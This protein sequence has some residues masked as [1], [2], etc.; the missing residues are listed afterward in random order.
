VHEAATAEEALAALGVGHGF[1]L[2]VLDEIYSDI[3]EAGMRGSDVI[4]LLRR[5]E[6]ANG[7]P[8]LPVITCTGI[9][10][11]NVALLRIHGA[12][13]VWDKPFPS[14]HD[15]TMQRL[16]SRLLASHVLDAGS[17]G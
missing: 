8:R 14:P 3:S 2:A 16:V 9:A 5:R 10:S 7:E 6:E 13:D 12:D 11:Q 4:K 15:G 17:A 1:H